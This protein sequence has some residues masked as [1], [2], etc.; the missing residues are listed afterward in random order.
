MSRAHAHRTDRRRTSAGFTLVELLVVIGIIALLISMLLPALNRA[1]DSART[2]ACLSNLR[3]IATAVHLYANETDGY[4]PPSHTWPAVPDVGDR[5]HQFLKRY[6][7]NTSGQTVWTC[8]STFG[9]GLNTEFPMTYGA[10]QSIHTF[11]HVALPVVPP[12][13]KLS[14]VRRSSEVI[15]VA[16]CSLSSGV[17]TSAGWLDNTGYPGA[18][19]QAGP[20]SDPNLIAKEILMETYIENLPGWSVDADRVGTPYHMRYR[21]NGNKMAN[22]VFVDGHAGTFRKRELKYRNLV[23]ASE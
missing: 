19:F 1:R 4:L 15:S 8:P 2:V 11:Q 7:P 3:Q 9:L 18:P 10:N 6:I 5:L 22:V 16:D 20:T 23:R 21:H 14:K 13:A 12:L 17:F